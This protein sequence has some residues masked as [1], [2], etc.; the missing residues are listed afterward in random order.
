MGNEIIMKYYKGEQTNPYD[1]RDQ[2]K[3]MLWFYERFYKLTIIEAKESNDP[4]GE[5]ISDYI[6]MGLGYFEYSDGVPMTLKAYLF[7]RYAKGSQSLAEAVEPFK[8]FYIKQYKE[9]D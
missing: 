4:F 8:K 5:Y 9:E 2:N 3:A 6:R 7:N 1:G